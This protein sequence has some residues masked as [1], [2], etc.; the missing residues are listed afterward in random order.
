MTAGANPVFADVDL[1]S[2][3]IT[4]DSIKA[5]LTPNTK[6]VIVGLKR[7]KIAYLV[8]DVYEEENLFF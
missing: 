8:L 1:N 6:A 3:V 5:A 4:A 2:Q 7:R